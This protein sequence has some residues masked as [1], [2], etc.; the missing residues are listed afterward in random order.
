MKPLMRGTFRT[1]ECSGTP[2]VYSFWTVLDQCDGEQS[3]HPIIVDECGR[4]LPFEPHQRFPR[5]VIGEGAFIRDN[6]ST[7]PFQEDQDGVL[8][9]GAGGQ[10][11][12]LTPLIAAN[13]ELPDRLRSIRGSVQ[14]S[15]H[16][17]EYR[18][19]QVGLALDEPRIVYAAP[20]R[21]Q[22][23][24]QGRSDDVVV[25]RAGPFDFDA[26]L[27]SE[28]VEASGLPLKRT[29]P[30]CPS[31]DERLFIRTEEEAIFIEQWVTAPSAQTTL[32]RVFTFR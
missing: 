19:G 28:N 12:T 1:G 7:S 23:A 18:D 24:F 13:V 11:F 9:V 17:Y 4:L 2:A 5:G 20:W 3:T 14:V 27:E 31:Y 30:L 21:G 16:V 22:A 32:R 8:T 26:V 29:V 6:G 15:E 25:V 10:A